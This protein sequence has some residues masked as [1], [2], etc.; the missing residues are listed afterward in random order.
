MIP[1]SQWSTQIKQYI[2]FIDDHQKTL[3][4]KKETITDRY[5]AWI[6]S[7]YRLV[8]TAMIP[9]VAF[10]IPGKIKLLDK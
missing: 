7:M 4:G 9:T 5:K 3:R 6:R 8:L 2:C 10:T 1:R